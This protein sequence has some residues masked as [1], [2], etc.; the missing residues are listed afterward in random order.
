MRV[1]VRVGRTLLPIAGLI[2][3]S[4]ACAPAEVEE[5]VGAVEPAVHADVNEALKDA[6][7]DQVKAEW[8]EARDAVH[9]RGFVF[10]PVERHRA[11][12]V[13]RDAAGGAPVINE[14]RVSMGAAPAP[15]PVLA[16]ASD[17]E[18]IDE[19][20]HGDV[21]ALFDDRDV[22][23]GRELKV[24]VHAGQV[25]L[26][27]EVLTQD[28]KDRV[29]EMVAGVAGVKGVVNRLTVRSPDDRDREP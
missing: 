21:E 27:G 20:I 24:A 7:L 5:P 26:T 19:R 14:L 6:R 1:I 4:A 9:L 16:S 11:E 2:L 15:A 10:N 17:L 8:S 23:G 3:L 22:W 25:R 18:R 29:T 12:T 13:A 28:E